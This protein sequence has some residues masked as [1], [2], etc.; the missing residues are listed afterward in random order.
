M[1]SEVLNKKANLEGLKAMYP[2]LSVIKNGE[3]NYK[4]VRAN[5]VADLKYNFPGAKFSITKRGFDGVTIEWTNGPALDK[6]EKVCKKYQD[7]AHDFSGDYWDYAPSNFNRMFG[8]L[9]YVFVTRKMSPEITTLGSD[10]KNI[11]LANNS[12]MPAYEIEHNFNKICWAAA[13]PEN[14]SNFRIE[15]TDCKAGSL[16]DFYKIAFDVPATPAPPAGPEPDK[17][18]PTNK[19]A[20]PGNFELVDYSEK[21]IALFGDTREIKDQLKEIG[22]RFNPYLTKNGAKASG[23][24][25]SKSKA[26]K[27]RELINIS[28]A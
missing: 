28:A 23:W 5:M 21:A 1:K 13:I 6:V 24:I 2:Y 3:N 19:P 17:K 20:A 7:H 14:A 12:N 10:F 15:K 22:G 8:G 25:F 4:N 11:M 27:V 18:A 26:D 9:E 16:S